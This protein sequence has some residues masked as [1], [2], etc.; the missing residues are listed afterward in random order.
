MIDHAA[1]QAEFER[2]GPWVTAFLIDGHVYGGSYH[3]ASDIRLGRFLHTF[4]GI[5]T[6]LE[7]GSLE[8]GHS[9]HLAAQPGIRR[10]VAVEGR[11][12][13][14]ARAEF[15]QDVLG[16]ANL[17][18]HTLDL[19]TA[20]LTQLGRFDAV[21]CMG[22]LY[23]LREPWRLLS[24]IGKVSRNLFVWTHYTESRRTHCVDPGYE[25]ASYRETWLRQARHPLSGLCRKAFWPTMASLEQMLHGA[26]FDTVHVFDRDPDHANGPCVLLS[27]RSTRTK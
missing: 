24:E 8:G 7:L 5:S 12:D 13:N 23:H 4:P 21:F 14:V 10:V 9:L 18:F 2:R 19:D 22:L 15:V 25:G 20:P 27:A 6:V 1:L 26:G 17:S 3:A 11:P 16:V